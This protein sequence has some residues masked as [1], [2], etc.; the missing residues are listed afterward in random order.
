[1]ASGRKVVMAGYHQMFP[2]ICP[3]LPKEQSQALAKACRAPLV[4]T[5]VLIRN[6]TSFAKLGLRYAYCPGSYC[7]NA[8]L[9][10]PV[11][12]GNYRC[13]T[14]PEEPMILHMTRPPTG[15]R[16]SQ[17]PGKNK[18][19]PGYGL[20]RVSATSPLPVPMQRRTP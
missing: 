3:D 1:M 12:L 17:A 9:D 15:S 13:P 5:N 14:A 16:S 4:Y 8:S 2:H 18:T 19:D 20:E 6:W 10:Y 11:S 7:H